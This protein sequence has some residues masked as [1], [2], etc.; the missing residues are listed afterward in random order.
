VHD[1]GDATNQ[2]V[3]HAV[4]IECADDPLD[5]ERR[6]RLVSQRATALVA[7]R[8]R[9]RSVSAWRADRRA[10]CV[11]HRR[12]WGRSTRPDRMISRT[13]RGSR[14]SRSQ[15][16][17]LSGRCPRRKSICRVDLSLGV[18]GLLQAARCVGH[19][20]WCRRPVRGSSSVVVC[21]RQTFTLPALGLLP[22]GRAAPAL[23]APLSGLS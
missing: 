18:C 17:H 13:R 14:A 12:L 8:T 20:P 11:T 1:A 6:G 15:H 5:V 21:Q 16:G 19:V 3:F 7:D 9:R 10:S 4:L 2:H 22:S 23:R